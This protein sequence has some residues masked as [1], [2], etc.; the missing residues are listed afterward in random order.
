MT[1]LQLELFVAPAANYSGF[2]KH[3][4][5]KELVNREDIPFPQDLQGREILRF[6]KSRLEISYFS[7]DIGSSIPLQLD[8]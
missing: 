1:E 5:R 7:R 2:A 8:E 6:Q 4:P 3:L